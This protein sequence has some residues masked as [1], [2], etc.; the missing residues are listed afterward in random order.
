MP[1]LHTLLLHLQP[2][3]VLTM[4]VGITIVVAL[5]G[6]FA[7]SIG[8]YSSSR[9]LWKM[10]LISLI[11]SYILGALVLAFLDQKPILAVILSAALTFVIGNATE[12]DAK[13]EKESG[14]N[15]HGEEMSARYI[16]ESEIEN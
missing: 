9:Q 15:D 12:K 2:A 14:K 10:L 13:D 16:Q 5:Y 8:L 7:R 11:S 1:S 4:L 6:I 3:N